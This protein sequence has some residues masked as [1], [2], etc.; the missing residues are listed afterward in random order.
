MAI[1]TI[2]NRYPNLDT[3]VTLTTP[4]VNACPHSGEPQPG[5]TVSVIYQPKGKLIELHGVEKY[6]AKLAGGDEALDLETVAQLVAMAAWETLGE[7]VKVEANYKLRD[8]LEMVCQV[9]L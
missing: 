3:T 6:L 5:S 1:E 9:S 4:F 8:D 7:S 2:P